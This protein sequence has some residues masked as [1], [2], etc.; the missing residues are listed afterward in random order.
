MALLVA[1]CGV[2]VSVSETE[3]ISET[4]AEAPTTAP[5]PAVEVEFVTPD[6]TSP[7]IVES[8]DSPRQGTVVA[9]AAAPGELVAYTDAA[10]SS[11]QVAVLTDPVKNGGAL[12]LQVIT[13][14]GGSIPEWLEVRLPVRPNGTT[15]WIKSNTVDLS[16]NPYRVE[17]TTSEFR[18]DLFKNDELVSTTSIAVGTGET[19]TPYGE[20]FLAELLQPSSPDGAYGPFA[21]GL[22]GFSDVIYSF[23]GGDGVIGIH[24]T[25][26]PEVIGTEVSHG[27]VRVE[28]EFIEDMASIVPLGTPVTIQH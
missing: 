25:N 16:L 20:F 15:G 27:C 13:P 14:V 17:I 2:E 21:F 10:E 12:V 5:P 3:S 23:A 11:E 8:D 19:P 1:S 6:T 22:S 18:L 24:G 9:R 28:N 7:A 4:A 26:Q